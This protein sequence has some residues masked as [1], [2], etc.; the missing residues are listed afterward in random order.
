MH[1]RKKYTETHTKRE[2]VRLVSRPPIANAV[3]KFA[4]DLAK[5]QKKSAVLNEAKICNG[6]TA[7]L[8]LLSL[9][10]FINGFSFVCPFIESKNRIKESNPRIESTNRIKESN[11]RI[12][13]MNRNKE[14]KQRIESKNRI[15]ESK[16]RIE[17]KNRIKESNQRIESMNRM[18]VTF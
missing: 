1:Q 11:H 17:S 7:G 13:A 18:Q 8:A 5:S 16:Q 6:K 10:R 3:L 14:W 4:E 9:N 12:E 15:K 2:A